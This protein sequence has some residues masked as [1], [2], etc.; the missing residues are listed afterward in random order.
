M[1]CF[2]CV[3]IF[4]D[5]HQKTGNAI[6][7]VGRMAILS[8]S[9]RNSTSTGNSRSNNNSS[10]CTGSR[11]SRLNE[12]EPSSPSSVN[13]FH[14]ESTPVEQQISE[15]ISRTRLTS[16]SD[17][18]ESGVGSSI[19]GGCPEE[20]ASS[21]S[22]KQDSIT[23]EEEKVSFTS[24][25][26][27][28]AA[29]TTVK[30]SEIPKNSEHSKKIEPS[31]FPTATTATTP[32]SSGKSPCVSRVQEVRQSW[33]SRASSPTNSGKKSSLS[34]DTALSGKSNYQ[35]AKAFWNR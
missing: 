24:L 19:G 11:M 29:D 17:I 13:G 12:E 35:K 27:A 16:D 14:C 34:N 20:G 6:R 1:F 22:E 28:T 7:A 26:E 21:N 31:I 32:T 33:E 2:V 5:T 30:S 3:S 9:R 25:S 4:C 23:E 18:S 15:Q 8:A 10:S